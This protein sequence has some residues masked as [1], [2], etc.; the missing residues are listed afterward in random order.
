MNLIG[1][2]VALVLLGVLFWAAHRILGVLPIEEPFK[3][4]IYVVLVVLAV[5]IILDIL[6][7]IPGGPYLRWPRLAR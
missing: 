5:V 7:G 1:L 6:V 2:L 4:V 3:T